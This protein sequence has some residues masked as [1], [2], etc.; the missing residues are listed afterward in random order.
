MSSGLED[1]L[2][3]TSADLGGTGESGE[4]GLAGASNIM[5]VAPFMG[6]HQ[7]CIC[8][9]TGKIIRPNFSLVSPAADSGLESV[10]RRQ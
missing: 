6:C 1:P 4:E 9:C 8:P 3:S 10:C 2:H 7:G 5:D